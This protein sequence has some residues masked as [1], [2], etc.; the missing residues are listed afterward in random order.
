MC[1]CTLW[2]HAYKWKGWGK[3]RLK[4]T[5]STHTHACMHA[6]MKQLSLSFACGFIK[7]TQLTTHGSCN[8]QLLYVPCRYL[9]NVWNVWNVC[10]MCVCGCNIAPPIEER[11][12]S[13]FQGDEVS[14]PGVCMCRL[15]FSVLLHVRCRLEPALFVKHARVA[16]ICGEYHHRR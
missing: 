8:N 14:R 15:S 7:I 3:H 13:C 16:T 1:D 2:L 9:W 10:I 12:N 4:Y 6:C 11:L 5:V